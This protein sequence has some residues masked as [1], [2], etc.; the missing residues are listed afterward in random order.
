M[1]ALR[2]NGHEMFIV[3]HRS[4]TPY[5]GPQYDLHAA[6]RAWL[7][8]TIQSQGLFDDNQVFFLETRDQK[9]RMIKELGCELFLDDLPEVL[10]AT[11]FPESTQGILFA[12]G[13]A[14]EKTA[15]HYTTISQW[16]NLPALLKL[17]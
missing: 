11:E 3:S 10:E 9:V 4:K 12:P 16:T 6:A 2:A 8:V 13:E 14:K 7:K 17:A 15:T 1:Q 5:A